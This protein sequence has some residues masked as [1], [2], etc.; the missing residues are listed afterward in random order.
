MPGL[1]GVSLREFRSRRPL[2]EP[3]PI[4]QQAELAAVSK[5][6]R[7]LETE[8]AILQRARDLLRESYGPQGGTRP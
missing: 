1:S 5:R 6:I 4:A 7:E 8:V 2:K 3:C